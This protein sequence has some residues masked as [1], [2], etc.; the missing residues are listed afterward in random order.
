[1]EPESTL[2]KLAA[3][4]KSWGSSLGFQQVAITDIDLT[5]YE[6]KLKAWIENRFHGEMDY[7]ARNHDK[8]THPDQLLP[9][10]VRVI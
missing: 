6:P 10:T 2:S 8:R 4:I 7:M 1:M 5:S 3:D 9:G